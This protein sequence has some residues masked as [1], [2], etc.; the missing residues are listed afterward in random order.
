[1]L[2]S[3]GLGEALSVASGLL[4]LG[5][6]AVRVWGRVAVARQQR[7]AMTTVASMLAA[8]GRPVRARRQARSEEWSIEI[9]APKARA[10]TEQS[11]AEGE[12]SR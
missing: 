2:G 3:S 11:A 9:D 6:L 1:M 5:A 4:A 7:R 8:T 12:R 10:L